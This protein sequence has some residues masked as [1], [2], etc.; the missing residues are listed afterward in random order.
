MSG[1][2]SIDSCPQWKTLSSVNL[3]LLFLTTK[4]DIIYL[5]SEYRP[6]LWKK[7]L[8][9]SLSALRPDIPITR[10]VIALLLRSVG[11]PPSE[12]VFSAKKKGLVV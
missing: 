5:V 6:I 2:Q 1:V 3:R 8:G 11:L 7:A 4:G 10:L 12:L 9:N